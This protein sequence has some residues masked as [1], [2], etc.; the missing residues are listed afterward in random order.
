MS[1]F[2]D[3]RKFVRQAVRIPKRGAQK[4]ARPPSDPKIDKQPKRKPPRQ[5]K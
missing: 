1:E 3:F 2:E 5:D 4:K